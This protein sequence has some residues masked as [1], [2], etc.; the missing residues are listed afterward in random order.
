MHLEGADILKIQTVRRAAKIP[1]E[2]F[3]RMDIGSLRGRRQVAQ[4]HVFDHAEP[5]RAHLWAGIGHQMVS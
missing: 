2:L 4:R 1:A 5:Q 3:D